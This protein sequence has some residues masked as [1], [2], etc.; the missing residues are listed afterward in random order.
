MKGYCCGPVKIGP[1]GPVPPIQKDMLPGGRATSL[2]KTF[3]G[4][5]ECVAPAMGANETESSAVRIAVMKTCT[6]ALMELK[7]IVPPRLGNS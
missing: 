1:L 4:G 7:F 2:G 6:A 5:A 3:T